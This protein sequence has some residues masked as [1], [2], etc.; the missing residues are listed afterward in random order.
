MAKLYDT[1]TLLAGA[2]TSSV[3]T[4][5]RV[6]QAEIVGITV[7]ITTTGT[8]TPNV[9]IEASQAPTATGTFFTL[10]SY[11]STSATQY[12][13]AINIADNPYTYV[14]ATNGGM[15]SGVQNNVTAVTCVTKATV[16]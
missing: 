12:N 2:G 13:Y 3:G 16:K 7:A 6:A 5:L 8:G 10:S 1:W 4:A 9:L 15:S 11:T 14:R